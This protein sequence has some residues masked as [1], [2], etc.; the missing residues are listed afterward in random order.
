MRSAGLGKRQGCIFPGFVLMCHL[1]SDM[2]PNIASN[3]KANQ[4]GVLDC[5]H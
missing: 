1:D 5:G 3:N 2:P 4:I